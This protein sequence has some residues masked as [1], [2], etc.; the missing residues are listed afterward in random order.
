MCAVSVVYDMFKGMPDSWYTPQHIQLFHQMVDLAKQFDVEAKQPDCAD[1]EKALLEEHIQ[2][3][4][5][6]VKD[7]R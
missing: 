1:P 6:Q 7:E 4:E 5:Q 2:E 3:L